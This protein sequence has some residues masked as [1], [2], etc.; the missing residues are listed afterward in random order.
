MNKLFNNLTKNDV[1]FE[2]LPSFGISLM[3]AEM[4]YKIGS[5][6][7]ECLAFLGT[8]YIAGVTL[9]RLYRTFSKQ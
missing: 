4:Y 5:F 2:L 1:V 8:W 6:T 9:R 7:L 3:I